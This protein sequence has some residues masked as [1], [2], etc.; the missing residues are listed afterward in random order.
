MSFMPRQIQLV[1]LF[2]IL[3][4]GFL[5]NPSARAEENY[6]TQSGSIH[7]LNIGEQ[8]LTLDIGSDNGVGFIFNEQTLVYGR[9]GRMT[10]E[11]IKTG[12]F[13]TIQYREED[14][15]RISSRVTLK[16]A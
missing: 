5:L 16:D 3:G 4:G 9:G 7:H 8:N 13:V 14:G 1:L 2:F 11:E 12:D 10:I 6:L 15:F